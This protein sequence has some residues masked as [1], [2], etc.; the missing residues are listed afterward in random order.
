[1]GKISLSVAV[2]TKDEEQH[3]AA[4]LTSVAFARQVVVVDS[5]SR[6]RTVEIARELGAEVYEEP[7]RGGFGAQKQFAIERCREEWILVLDADERVPPATAEAITAA[8]GSAA[9]E[10]A[11]FSFPRKNYFQGRWI[12]HAGWWPDRLVRLFRRGR[13]QMSTASVHEGVEVAGPI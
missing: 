5:G 7:W 6:D 4:C 9:P 11:A 12:R 1:M 13:G 3:I 2:I 10:V 8:L